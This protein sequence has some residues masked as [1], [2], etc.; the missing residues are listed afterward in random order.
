MCNGITKQ[1]APTVFGI[2][3]KIQIK[4]TKSICKREGFLNLSLVNYYTELKPRNTRGN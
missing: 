4:L 1:N 2:M 3:Q